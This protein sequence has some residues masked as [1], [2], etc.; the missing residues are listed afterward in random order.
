VKLTYVVPRYGVEILGGAEYAARML[1]ERLVTQRGWEV[2][3]LTT[4]ALDTQT[5]ADELPLGNVSINGVDVHRFHSAS[6][7][8][9]RFD[10]L[11]RVVLSAP[12]RA[13]QADQLKWVDMQGPR[14]PELIAAV[15]DT[16]ADLVAFY[17]YL[18]HPTV[19]G[20]PAVGPRRSVFHPAAH[21]EP[22]LRLPIYRKVFRE[23]GGFVFQTESE[24]ELVE[25][26]FGIGATPQIVLGLGVEERPGR[27]DD[28]RR[29]LGLDDRP[30]LLYVG[31]VDH[32]KGTGAL[33]DFFRAY[34][35]LRPGP[36]RLVLAGDLVHAPEPADDVVLTG[37]VDDETKWGLLRGATA[38]VNPS[39]FEAFSLV[40]IEAWTAGVPVVVNARCEPTRE[41]CQ[42]SNG[43]LWY[44]S[45]GGFTAVLD[46]LLR[47]DDLRASLARSG[48]DYVRAQFAWPAL[49]DRYATFL[50][51]LADRARRRPAPT[52]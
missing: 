2:E 30:Y 33:V 23:V 1:A 34:K 14:S 24:R 37:R 16:D 5:W 20:V 6:G 40:T 42:R 35:K 38:F 10:A 32:G 22:P 11:S 25:A 31:R 47:D 17:P 49:I 18:F 50:E 44:Q 52:G 12:T 8:H 3:V 43:G 7:R 9:P 51:H 29:R 15:G 36:L 39:A 13:S 26:T 28:A 41:H 4:G 46:R 27:A 21:D 45:F 19:H 48:G